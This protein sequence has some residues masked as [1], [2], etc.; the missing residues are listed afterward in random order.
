MQSPGQLA[1]DN[2]EVV[3]EL[4]VPCAG[5]LI[6]SPPAP[7]LIGLIG[8]VASL[9]FTDELERAV[10][11]GAMACRRRSTEPSS[12]R[13]NPGAPATAHDDQ[14]HAKHRSR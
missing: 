10:I 12:A 6:G 2:P 13:S 5:Q 7:D 8:L 11:L 9:S 4:D 14:V 1:E 3:A